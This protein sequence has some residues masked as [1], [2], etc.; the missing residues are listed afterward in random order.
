MET[1][2]GYY[3]APQ[4][5]VEDTPSLY[6]EML[7]SRDYGDRSRYPNDEALRAMGDYWA[8]QLHSPERSPRAKKEIDVLLGRISF[9]LVMRQNDLLR[10]IDQLT[11]CLA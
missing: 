10:E 9:E 4:P 6:A 2:Q 8:D 1:Q 7:R 11:Q 3:E 5:R